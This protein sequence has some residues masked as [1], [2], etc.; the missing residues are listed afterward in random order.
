MDDE[1]GGSDLDMGGDGSG[2]DMNGD[3][4][5]SGFGDTGSDIGGLDAD[6]GIPEDTSGDF[7][8][9]KSGNETN[10]ETDPDTIANLENQGYDVSME[11]NEPDGNFSNPI[12]TSSDT[13]DS[14]DIDEDSLENGGDDN[15]V[16]EQTNPGD[17][18]PEDTQQEEKPDAAD[19]S[20]YDPEWNNPTYEQVTGEADMKQME[21][22]EDAEGEPYTSSEYGEAEASQH[23]QNKEFVKDFNENSAAAVDVS[24]QGI[25]GIDHSEMAGAVNDN[26]YLVEKETNLGEDNAQSMQDMSGTISDADHFKAEQDNLAQQ[27]EEIPEEA[28]AQEE[29]L[30][31]QM[32]FDDTKEK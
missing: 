21:M 11:V 5:D 3:N 26:D 7:S 13:V 18:I 8:V 31:G 16:G 1:F 12:T 17:D 27:Y 6:G 29:Q 2:F 20:E 19:Y 10:I 14:N 23:E 28:I 9:E 25:D 30:N 22:R 24:G 4:L 32:E 15:S